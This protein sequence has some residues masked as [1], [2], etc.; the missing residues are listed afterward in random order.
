[1]LYNKIKAWEATQNHR[2]KTLIMKECASKSDDELVKIYKNAIKRIKSNMILADGGF[3]I[4]LEYDLS[5]L[6]K[7]VEAVPELNG[8]EQ[9]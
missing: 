3:L 4:D 5:V 1:M 6:T 2:S 9:T 7:L 8:E